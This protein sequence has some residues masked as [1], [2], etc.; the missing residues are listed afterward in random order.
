MERSTRPLTD[1]AH[2]EGR[3]PAAP[4]LTS[5]DSRLYRRAGKRA[6][7][8]ALGLPFLV[9]SIPVILMLAACVVFTSG[10][11]PFYVATRIGQKGRAFRMWKLRTMVR[12]AEQLLANW[13]ESRPELAD[14]FARG[15]KLEA[16]PRV[17]ALGKLLRRGSL[18]E[19]PQL[20]NVVRGDMS[21]VGPRPITAREVTL[22][23]PHAAT[24]LATRPGMTGKW[25]V[26]G[27]NRISYPER[28]NVELSYCEAV[29]FLAD[30]KI[31]FR[32]IK[33]VV[34]GGGV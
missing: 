26:G 14:R 1:R 19:L 28:L 12:D 10:W 6:L 4:R 33:T 8:L 3:V 7:D 24:L 31:L 20:L 15:F 25:Q 34:S 30:L 13:R 21:F 17:T 22:Y 23:G 11:P 9:A 2:E 5:G 29:S 27:R 16:D 32:T 18:D